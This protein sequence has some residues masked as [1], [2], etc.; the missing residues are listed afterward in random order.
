[1]F[2]LFGGKKKK[3]LEK[4]NKA[5]EAQSYINE[6]QKN[7]GLPTITPS[8]FLDKGEIAFLEEHTT[9]LETRAV[10]K[11]SSIGG[12][13]GLRVAKGLYIGQGSRSGTSESTQEW[14][15]IDTGKVIITNQ[16][17]I[18]DGEKEN[19]ILKIKDIMSISVSLDAIE[20]SAKSKS[21][22]MIFS[23]GNGYIWGAVINIIRQT[24]NPL[25]LEGIDLDIKFQ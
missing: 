12:G 4:N 15:A 14:K 3:E 9:L 18:F 23:V 7:K 20:I 22:S 17:I 6:V 11:Y 21:K 1:M 24:D 5:E 13:V 8:I 25:N 19:R 10:T 16:N 2:G